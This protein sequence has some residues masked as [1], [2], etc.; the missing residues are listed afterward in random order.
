MNGKCTRR[1]ALRKTA[2]AAA[3]T[4]SASFLLTA[5]SES[6]DDGIERNIDT[7]IYKDKARDNISAADVIGK[8]KGFTGEKPN[9]VVIL[10]DDMG[11]GDLGCYGSSAI[12]TPNIDRLSR[13]GVHFTD[14]YSCNALCSPSR[15]GLLTGRYPHRTGV[16]FPIWPK[17]DNLMRSVSRAFGTMMAKLGALD[18]PNGESLND[19]LPPSEITIAEALKLA[20]YKT[21]AIG[22]WH[23]GDFTK[24]PQY[25]P[26][27]HGFDFFTGFNGSNDDWPSAFWRNQKEITPDIELDQEK[28]T[29]IFT[30]EAVDFINENS[31]A[32]FFLYL[33]HKDPHQPCFPS[34]RFKGSS[35]AGPHGDVI[36]EVDWSVGEIMKTLKKQGID[37][38]TLVIF[39]SDN[40]PWFNG[41]PVS[42]RGRKGQSYEGGFNVPMIA[43][44]PG[45]IPA[46]SIC[47][48]PSMNIDFFPTFLSLAGLKIPKDRI[49]DG[50][51]ITGL[52]NGDSK[53]TP[54][55]A[56]FFFHENDLEGVR[57]GD[58]KYF[59]YMN[60]YVHPIVVDNPKRTLSGLITKKAQTYTGKDSSGKERTIPV[61]GSFPMLYNLKTD[62]GENY[63]LIESYPRVGEKML[64][65]MTDWEKEFY[66]NPRGWK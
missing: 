34:K 20:G 60:H 31:R 65:I 53:K 46:G 49:I 30:K 29:G 16:T 17:N 32:P 47:R 21:A 50:K 54:H 57:A 9:V 37:K 4:T 2:L 24:Q 55:D 39:T 25:H 3:A 61:M 5:C 1:E 13:E 14:F 45:K 27:R 8:K 19:G 58:Y 44:Y 43:R 59:R 10:C 63:N 64:K 23:L 40:G 51:D 48:E 26:H 33:A 18:L 28:Y 52:L 15:A 11:Y 38:K 12:K 66:K 35:K 6:M 22:K 41:S 42:N 62:K 36:Q 56:L 7:G